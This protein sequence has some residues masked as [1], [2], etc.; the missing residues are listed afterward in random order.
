MT[1][2][3]REQVLKMIADGRISAEEG[4]K[5][6]NVL[7]QDVPEDAAPPASAHPASPQGNPKHEYS[8]MEVDPRIE[9]VKSIVQ[10]L[11]Q[12]PLWIGVGILILS[13]L[14]MAALGEAGKMNFWFFFLILPLLPAWVSSLSLS[15]PARHVGFSS[16]SSK[17]PAKNH[18]ASS[19][20]SLFPSN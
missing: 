9:K 10:R 3:E 19:S 15:V 12:I 13:A 6:M 16:M 5:L 4:L 17:N 11:W 1:N 2:H 14:G 7:D 18:S 8:R 20:V